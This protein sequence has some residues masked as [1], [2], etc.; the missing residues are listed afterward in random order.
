EI[1]RVLEIDAKGARFAG[2]VPA[3]K[4]LVDGYG[5]G[6]VGNIVLRDRRHLS[7][8]GLIVVVATVDTEERL[9]ISGPEIISR[10]FIYVREAEELMEEARAV[11]FDSIMSILERRERVDRI[12]LKRRVQDDLT[13]FLYAKTHRKPM[14][15]PIIMNI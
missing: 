11:A 2:E 3:G 13:R 7:Q 1:G 5:V 6:D 10:G 8:D 9:L 14:I 15:L 12:K 4:I